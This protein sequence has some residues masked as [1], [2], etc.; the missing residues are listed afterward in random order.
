MSPVTTDGRL[1][2]ILDHISRDETIAL[3]RSLACSFCEVTVHDMKQPEVAAKAKVYGVRCVP[4][5]L[6]D[7]KLADC[8]TGRGPH[9]QALR[10]AGIGMHL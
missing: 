5:V 1:A 4:A 6:V 3:V 7:G 2:T 9:E 8:C 10:A